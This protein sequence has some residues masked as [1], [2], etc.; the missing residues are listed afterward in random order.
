MSPRSCRIRGK[1]KDSFVVLAAMDE[2]PGD[3]IAEFWWID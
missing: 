2:S 1:K 3:T